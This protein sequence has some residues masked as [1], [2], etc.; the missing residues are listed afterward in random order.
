MNFEQWEHNL[1]QTSLRV[2]QHS[3]V[4]LASYMVALVISPLYT[5]ETNQKHA[6]FHTEGL[7]K[8]VLQY[9]FRSCSHFIHSSPFKGSKVI[10]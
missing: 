8:E 1:W 2:S 10:E 5:Q 7:K 6:D 9:Y 3:Q 4:H